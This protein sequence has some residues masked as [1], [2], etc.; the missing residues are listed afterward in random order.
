MRIRLFRLKACF[1]LIPFYRSDIMLRH[2]VGTTHILTPPHNLSV[3]TITF[4]KLRPLPYLST[5]SKTL[6][7]FTQYWRKERSRS[8]QE[9]EKVLEESKE[10]SNQQDVI[11]M[12]VKSCWH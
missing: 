9:E 7:K 12:H 5:M 10:P 6:R 1:L 4:Y 2:H 11:D 8:C 3:V